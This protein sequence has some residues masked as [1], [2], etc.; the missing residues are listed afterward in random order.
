MLPFNLPDM[1][2]VF[3]GYIGWSYEL[4]KSDDMESDES[5]VS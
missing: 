3:E 2:S 4:W 5:V 1:G